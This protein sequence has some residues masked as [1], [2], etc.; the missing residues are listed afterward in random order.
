MNDMEKTPRALRRQSIRYYP[1][2]EN[3]LNDLERAAR[4]SQRLS[5]RYDSERPLEPVANDVVA[6][7]HPEP[8]KDPR[9]PLNWSVWKKNS[10]LAIVMWM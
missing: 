2:L 10:I 6:L 9:D 8:T 7:L 3:A 5:V 1:D 4:A